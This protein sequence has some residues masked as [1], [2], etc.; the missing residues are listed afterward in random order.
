M[1]GLKRF[2]DG[3]QPRSFDLKIMPLRKDAPIILPTRDWLDFGDKD[4]VDEVESITAI[5]A[6]EVVANLSD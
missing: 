5:P 3:M 1:I 2:L 6:Y 4:A